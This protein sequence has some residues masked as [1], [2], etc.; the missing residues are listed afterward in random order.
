MH[1]AWRAVLIFAGIFAGAIGLIGCRQR[2]EPAKSSSICDPQ[3]LDPKPVGGVEV[4]GLAATSDRPI[5]IYEDVNAWS[6]PPNGLPALTL[7]EDGVAIRSTEDGGVTTGHVDGA[8]ALAGC[9]AQ[10]LAGLPQHIEASRATD[11]PEVS[12]RARVG[13]TW[14]SVSVVGLRRGDT[15][16]AP[17][18]P[19][20]P[21]F[22]ALRHT[23]LALTLLN[24][25]PLPHE[26]A[27]ITI[28]DQ[29]YIVRVS[30]CFSWEPQPFHVCER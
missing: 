25:K 21:S 18:N 4:S 7:Y 9:I 2:P 14:R 6:G 22:L 16:A 27:A 8:G 3:P 10:G 19:V 28:P 29:R 26:D 20:P 24:E 12:V 23:L 11:Q 5:L 30:R 13:D 17:M 1:A 15:V